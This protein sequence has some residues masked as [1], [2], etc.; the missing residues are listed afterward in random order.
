VVP[1]CP[2]GGRAA[3][4][5]VL[6]RTAYDP[7][8]PKGA[9]D[10]TGVRLLPK[11][12]G[13]RLQICNFPERFVS[14]AECIFTAKDAASDRGKVNLRTEINMKERIR[15]VSS[16]MR[17]AL[18]GGALIAAG[19]SIAFNRLSQANESPKPAR[20]RLVVDEAPVR[21]DSKPVMSFAPVVK[22]VAPSVVKVF[23]TTKVK[24]QRMPFF[25]DPFFRRF[26]GEDGLG[27]DGPRGRSFR[28]P[29]Q[30]GLGSGVIVSKDGY[31]VTNNHVVE[32]ADEIK[33][34]LTDG[35][36]LPA[37]VVGTDAKSEI[38]VLKVDASDLTP[39]PLA[40][41]DQIEVGD[42]VLAVGNPF[43]I[44]QTVTMGI[45][46][47]TGR[48]TLGLDYEDFIQT[49]AAINPGN[50][51]GALVDAEG[52]LI[53]INTAILSRSGGNQGIGFAV[54]SNLA[55]SVMESLIKNGRVIRGFMGVNI[56]DVTPGLAKEFNLPQN[57][58]G[59]LVAEVTPRSPADKAG[60]KSGDVIIEFDGKPVKDSRHLKLQVAQVAPGTKVPVKFLRDG[61]EK[62]AEV[63]LKEF[64]K[65]EASAQRR[66]GDNESSASDT[67]DG[68]TVA[69]IDAAARQQ[70]GLPPNL[71]GALVVQVDEDS[72]SYEAGLREGDVILEIN[73]KPVRNADDAVQ[74]SEQIK[75]KRILL[76]IW[77]RG[78]S[79]YL[80]VDES[81]AG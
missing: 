68:V 59:A 60:L 40:D 8:R 69:D 43:G 41:S 74:L 71:K 9:K 25:N 73:R 76:R 10:G 35:R 50:S 61:D 22:Q 54:P 70:L 53:G 49:D 2:R 13:A 64:P 32:N 16:W 17:A 20:V 66:P 75:E 39:L 47:A 77:S 52:R 81:K 51:G 3:L 31:I 30:Y 42:L 67:L 33:V 78:G 1:G 63:V 37:K 38:A 72:A 15:K 29:R 23:T 62:T 12:T 24:Q 11:Q 56:Q 44:G 7:G 58:T 21:R 34:G 4:A 65:D 79:R 6:K 36:E 46:S 80:V 45:V 57:T 5:C 48:A 27:D 18:L 26:F 28:A 19:S 55:R 14:G